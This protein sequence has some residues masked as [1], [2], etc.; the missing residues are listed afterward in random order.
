MIGVGTSTKIDTVLC[1]GVQQLNAGLN[2]NTRPECTWYCI[3][4]L[5]TCD[6]GITCWEG[7]TFPQY[8]SRHKANGVVNLVAPLL[9]FR[10][11]QGLGA[12]LTEEAYVQGKKNT[13]IQ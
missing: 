1:T 4:L 5:L 2:Y 9:P 8:T 10:P 12:D 13:C 6:L 3:R 11:D 7:P